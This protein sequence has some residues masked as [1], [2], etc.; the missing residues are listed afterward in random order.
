MSRGEDDAASGSPSLLVDVEASQADG[1]LAHLMRHKLRARLD[2]VDLRQSHVS[3]AV[4]PRDPFSLTLGAHGGPDEVPRLLRLLRHATRDGPGPTAIFADPRNGRMGLRATLPRSFSLEGVGGLPS[5][6]LLDYHALR[7]LLGLPEG[8]EVA[9]VMPLEWNIAFMHGVSFDKGCYVGQE[10]VARTHFRGLVRKRFVPVYFS[11]AGSPPRSVACAD[12]VAAAMVPPRRLV[13]HKPESRL[14]DHSTSGGVGGGHVRLNFPFVDRA[15]KGEVAVGAPVASDAAADRGVRLGRVTAWV[16]GLN[17]G[18]ALLR[19]EHVAHTLVKMGGGPGEGQAP[20]LPPSGEGT[21]GHHGKHGESLHR[22]PAPGMDAT[23]READNPAAALPASAHPADAPA[24]GRD[25]PGGVDAEEREQSGGGW[26][27]AMGEAG[28]DDAVDA[29]FALHK[30]CAGREVD[31]VTAP[32][33][34]GPPAASSSSHHSPTTAALAAEE[35]V[36][37]L[38]PHHQHAYHQP[39]HTRFRVTPVLPVWWRHI[40]SPGLEE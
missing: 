24:R 14:H 20:P 4:V 27:G 18:L 11:A 37:L 21:S 13:A 23:I 26:A 5:A 35:G 31:F 1:L 30:R 12:P 16:P 7:L 32:V 33:P 2:V 34:A 40:A 22:A 39:P 10:L 8:R 19:L 25:V 17:L 3:V 6:S 15:W 29:Y 38:H 36:P 9:D 28:D